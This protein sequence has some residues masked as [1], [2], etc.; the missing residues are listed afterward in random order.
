ADGM[1]A[2]MPSAFP[3]LSTPSPSNHVRKKGLNSTFTQEHYLYEA[4]LLWSV[5]LVAF[6]FTLVGFAFLL[7]E[8]LLP[9][10]LGSAGG[11]LLLLTASR[12]IRG[13]SRGGNMPQKGHAMRN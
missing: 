4:L 11:G 5:C 2:M 12:A 9:K 6:G 13:R 3:A 10:G 7:H 8:S 1:T